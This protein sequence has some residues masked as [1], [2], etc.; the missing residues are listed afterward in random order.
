M[1]CANSELG[2]AIDL[3]Q[4]AWH[5][6]RRDWGRPAS[7]VTQPVDGAKGWVGVVAA[8]GQR[9]RKPDRGAGMANEQQRP[10]GGCCGWSVVRARWYPRGDVVRWC[11][12]EVPQAIEWPQ[13]V[14]DPHEGGKR[15]AAAV[16]VVPRER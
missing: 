3:V 1:F 4:A 2:K 5:R 16:G 6:P 9:Q 15:V 14:L 8:R 13:R 12:C 10:P 11:L 7:L